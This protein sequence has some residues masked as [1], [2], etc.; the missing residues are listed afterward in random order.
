M[1]TL[2]IIETAYRASAEEQDDTIVWFNTMCR[3]AGH[4]ISVLLAAEA[5]NYGVNGHDPASVVLQGTVVAEPPKMDADLLAL[6]G[7]EVD[8]FYV[9]EDRTDLGIPESAMIA[10]AK[11]VKRSELASLCAGFD[12]VWHW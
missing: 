4:D 1:K 2:S 12:Q 6:A 8:I 10:Q 7:R 3:D 9:D 5:V 11:P